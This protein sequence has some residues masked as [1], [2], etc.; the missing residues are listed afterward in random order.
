M[1]RT[2]IKVERHEAV[3]LITLDDPERRNPLGSQLA[4]ELVEVF[5]QADASEEVRALVLTG[6]GPAFCAGADVEELGALLKKEAMALHEAGRAVSDVLRAASR[7]RKPLIAAVNGYAL[8][9]GFALAA[10]CHVVFACE[11]ACFGLPE[12][13]LGLFPLVT[14]HYVRRAIG[15]HRALDLAL[16][17]RLM[18]ALE[19]R[20]AGFVRDVIP[21]EKLIETAMAYAASVCRFSPAVLSLG[22]RAL[23][24]AEGLS[25]DEATEYLAAVRTISLTD[26]EVRRG[27]AAF[28]EKSGQGRAIPQ[29]QEKP[30]H[31]PV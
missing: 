15:H 5:H 9:A 13:R 19:A 8:G 23:R 28:V 20:S 3:S 27:V 7:L 29:A 24:Y 1:E 4:R 6:S 22:L 21:L 17:G 16:S 11:S 2:H 18:G 12:A 26:K 31:A 14:L 10:Q 30:G 25:T